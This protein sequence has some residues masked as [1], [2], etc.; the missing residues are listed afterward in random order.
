MVL[1]RLAKVVTPL[2]DSLQLQRLTGREELS[3]PFSYELQLLSTDPEVKAASLLGQGMTVELELEDEKVRYFHGIVSRFARGGTLGRYA[4][5]RA[6][7]RPWLWLLSRTSDCRIFQN[8]TAPDVIKQIFRDFGLTDFDDALSGTYRTWDYIVQYRETALSFV[9]R[10]MEQEGIYY[11]FRHDSNK[12]TLVL[13]DGYSAHVAAPG[14]EEV[15]YLP[16]DQHNPRERDHLT[17]WT[18]SEQIQPGAYMLNDFDFVRPKAN[19]QSKIS[20]PRD[21]ASGD[22]EY[23]DYP[24]EYVEASDGESYSKARLQA[25]QAE[26][27]LG[28]GEGNVRGLS[29]GNLFKLTRF[30]LE[31]QNREYL[32]VGTSHL[33]ENSTRESDPS[34]DVRVEASVDVIESRVQ[35]RAAQL[36]PK[37]MISGPQTA[38]VVGKA[39][40][41]IWTDQYGRVKVQ[42]HWD[43]VGKSD[44]NSSCWVRVAQLWAG[45]RWGGMHIPRI[46]QEVIVEFLEGDP[47]R[48]IV[49]GRVYNGDNRPPYDLPANQTQS[50]IKSRS[51]KGGNPDNFNE[52]RFE[53]KKGE[54]QVYLQA[55]KNMDALVKN[56][57]TL[58]VNHDRTKTIGNDETT[59]VT[60]FRTET[61]KKDEKVTIVGSRTEN[62]GP[63]EDIT[64]SG[65]RRESVGA[66][67]TI[68]IGS[69]RTESVGADETINIAAAR[70]TTIGAGE[71][72]TVMAT[73][74]V[75]V[76]G[77]HAETVGGA[78]AITVAGAQATSVAGMQTTSVLGARAVSVVGAQT[79]AIQGSHTQTVSK[80]QTVNV[81]G[82]R[83]QNVGKDD[84]LVVGKSLVVS[85]ADDIVL[86]AGDAS[87]T[88][89]KNGDI[90]IKGKNINVTGSGKIKA[91][92]DGD[93]VLKASKIAQN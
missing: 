74:T 45:G 22:L 27:E 23:Y 36:T 78:Q 52:L 10:L 14:Y 70:T 47:D 87:I 44:E 16:P 67:E 41:E 2:G 71:V 46:G 84:K 75:T 65:D 28:A 38:I 49:T 57:E 26:C 72:L 7:M 29:A 73:R 21:H 64:I 60:G 92:A 86:K 35:F 20:A 56:D 33:I 81:T 19:L 83:S 90:T 91:N 30:P 62:V 69:S 4:V 80:D 63:F 18:V 1:D 39:G 61:V 32:I 12:H 79:T 88:L 85:A 93:M 42:F 48:P 77:A 13:A 53:D 40:E 76:V 24:G 31:D 66:T 17:A 89:K 15:P 8:T 11:Y 54:E 9:S 68:T 5:Y 59:T 82:A 58:T 25:L 50:G 43:R 6:T 37:P 3:R 34:G 51:T 55:E